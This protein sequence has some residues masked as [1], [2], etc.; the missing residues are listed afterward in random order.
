[1]HLHILL[2]F[3]FPCLYPARSIFVEIGPWHMTAQCGIVSDIFPHGPAQF[4]H[5]HCGLFQM[6]LPMTLFS[7]M[8]IYNKLFPPPNVEAV[9]TFPFLS[10]LLFSIYIFPLIKWQELI[11]SLKFYLEMKNFLQATS[12]T[13]F[14]STQNRW[15]LV[16]G[17]GW[18]IPWYP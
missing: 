14:G 4:S 9:I 13:K 15:T 11:R 1:M 10:L 5:V 2:F 3:Q 16:T 8:Y 7:R 12:F 6:A 17:Q 18:D